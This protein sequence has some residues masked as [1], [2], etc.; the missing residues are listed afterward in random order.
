VVGL[1]LGYFLSA[2][3]GLR[4]THGGIVSPVWPPAG[5]ALAGLL[6]LGRRVWPGIVIAS[7]A[8]G[9]HMG[10]VIALSGA[11]AQTLAPLTAAT[12]LASRP[13][14]TS[15][16]RVG[17]V[18]HLVVVG[19]AS[20]LLSAGIGTAALVTAG[21]VDTS[22]WARV[23]LLWWL[24][25][26]MGV[27]LVTPLLLTLSAP[28][29]IGRRRGEAAALVAATAISTR[30]LFGGN[31][32]LIFLV[33]PFALWAGLR[34]GP[35]VAAAVNTIVAGVAIWATAQGNGPFSTLPDTA[36]FAVLE[37][38]NAGVAITSLVLAGAVSTAVRLTAENERLHAQIRTQL[39]EVVAS[40][41]RIV[42][43]GYR[44][45]RRVER[46]LHDGAQQRLVSLAYSLGLALSRLKP[47][48]SPQLQASLVR[49]SE[50]VKAA[51]S[52]LRALAQG[53][54]PAVLTQVG[55][56]AALESLAEQMAL[57]VEVE[58]PERRYPPVVEAT[59]Y[60]VASEALTNVAKHAHA[61]MARVSIAEMDGRLIL[62]V[63]DDGIGGAD[64]ARGSGL[65]GLV[66]RV[67]AL[68]GRVMID[69]PLGR[70]T[71]VRAELPCDW[72]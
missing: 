42:Q 50:D 8:L 20:M 27:V 43:A 19:A 38:F 28:N 53:I 70:G 36:R 32:P 7:L 16:A 49:A 39:E 46:D 61:T 63:A 4:L 34:L 21:A 23:G 31:L 67:A 64:P 40:R 60:F 65:T 62:S 55:L 12:V 33:F 51:L 14:T 66:D 26:T 48:E 71:E 69:S 41:A 68:E 22:A 35:A 29:P 25:D 58:A 37:A 45:R 9:W 56:V 24:G 47:G 5:V 10:P 59:A 72:S 52:E 57:P 17:D 3:L 6:V 30:L 13:F 2:R 11:A 1:G 44:E 54:H 18:V 15:L